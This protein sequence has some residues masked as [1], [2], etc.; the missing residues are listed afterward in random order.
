MAGGETSDSQ[1]V[2]VNLLAEGQAGTQALI[3]SQSKQ[4]ASQQTLGKNPQLQTRRF[5][6][7]KIN[8]LKKKKSSAVLLTTSELF[9]H[10]FNKTIF[11]VGVWTPRAD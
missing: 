11:S 10:S 5:E 7:C 1:S 9:E 8:T 6:V 3:G 2:E 4:G